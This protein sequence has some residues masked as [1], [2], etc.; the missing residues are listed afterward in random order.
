MLKTAALVFACA[1][2][3]Y[4]GSAAAFCVSNEGSTP[5]TIQ[6][7]GPPMPIYVK[8]DLMP[9]Q[10]D[11]YVPRKPE[12]ITVEI[13]DSTNRRLRCRHS[14]PARDATITVGKTCRVK[15]D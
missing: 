12:G 13:Y 11:C 5:I 7:G 6:A 3:C 4:A 1:A 2:V 9:G 10:R 15:L 8:P 14:V